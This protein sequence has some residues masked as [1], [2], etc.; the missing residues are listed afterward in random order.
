MFDRDKLLKQAKE[1]FAADADVLDAVEYILT[2]YQ[3]P[4]WTVLYEK[5][6][7]F[8]TLQG[9]AELSD[10]TIKKLIKH[11]KEDEANNYKYGIF[12]NEYTMRDQSASIKMRVYFI[13][14]NPH[15]DG[16]WNELGSIQGN[17]KNTKNQSYKLSTVN[18]LKKTKQ[19]IK[20]KQGLIVFLAKTRLINTST[21]SPLNITSTSLKKTSTLGKTHL[22]NTSTPL[23]LKK[24]PTPSLCYKM[25]C[26]WGCV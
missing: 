14:F 1:Q 11:F 19:G 15:K 23:S 4:Y 3:S 5:H 13:H 12:I 21:P 18:Y 6:Y 17:T 7:G 8:H 20:L 10:S 24:T 16:E 9:Q 26:K 22:T 2:E 25:H